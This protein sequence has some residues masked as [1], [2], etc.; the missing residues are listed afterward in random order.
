MHRSTLEP[1][2]RF[3]AFALAQQAVADLAQAAAEAAAVHAPI[4]VA[5]FRL[6]H[7]SLEQPLNTAYIRTP[8]RFGGGPPVAARP[9]QRVMLNPLDAAPLMAAV[10]LETPAEQLHAYVGHRD[11][12]NRCIVITAVG[13]QSR[14][15][16]TYPRPVMFTS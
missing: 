4:Y 2:Q 9:P 5:L 6:F 10:V 16:A 14:S 8:E 15:E 11:H 12:S 1:Q 3:F 7:H 13:D